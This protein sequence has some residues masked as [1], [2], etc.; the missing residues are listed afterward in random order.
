MAWFTLM[1]RPHF[2]HPSG[3]RGR[4]TTCGE[5]GGGAGWPGAAAGTAGTIR[6]PGFDAGSDAGE[7]EVAC[8]RV[9]GR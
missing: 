7:V 1:L 8:V 5:G 9:G 2:D 3:C 4:C 6:Q